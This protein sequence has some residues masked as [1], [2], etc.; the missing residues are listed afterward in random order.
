MRFLALSCIGSI[1]SPRSPK[2]RF[3]GL[4]MTLLSMRV[5]NDIQNRQEQLLKFL[6]KGA[7][8]PGPPEAGLR[9]PS[10]WTAC[11]KASGKSGAVCYSAVF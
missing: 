2:S 7:V 9:H 5:P 11:F 10:F 1:S 8:E 6:Q 4:R 3:I